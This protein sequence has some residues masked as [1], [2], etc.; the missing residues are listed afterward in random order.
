[1]RTSSAKIGRSFCDPDSGLHRFK[2]DTV[3]FAF[4]RRIRRQGSA[5]RR[6][7]R[8][9]STQ[10]TGA[11]RVDDRALG[12]H[13]ADEPTNKDRTAPLRPQHPAY[14]LFTSGSAG[15]PKGVVVAHQ[16]IAAYVAV[17]REVLHTPCACRC[18]PQPCSILRS[19][20]CSSRSPRVAP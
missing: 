4:D 11:L 1:M 13:R 16:S 14:V 19:P 20:A 18:S 8:R 10:D 15:K 9:R 2:P 7:A 6:R 3:L 12:A 5:Y 17:L